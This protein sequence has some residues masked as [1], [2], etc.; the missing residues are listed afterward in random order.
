M[1]TDRDERALLAAAENRVCAPLRIGPALAAVR[2]NLFPWTRGPLK[3]RESVACR[4]T[5][6]RP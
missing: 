5:P 4:P 3:E 2:R 1:L 6:A